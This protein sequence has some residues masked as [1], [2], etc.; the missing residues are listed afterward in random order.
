MNMN[1][2]NLSRQWLFTS[3]RVLLILI[4]LFHR[5]KWGLDSEAERQE[6]NVWLDLSSMERDGE[7]TQNGYSTKPSASV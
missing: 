1:Y 6:E 2:Y 7:S 4:E 5:V 3:D